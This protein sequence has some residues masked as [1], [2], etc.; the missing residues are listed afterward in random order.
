MTDLERKI[1]DHVVACGEDHCDCQ[2]EVIG[3][4]Q[5]DV[6]GAAETMVSRGVL[7]GAFPPNPNR[8][9]GIDWGYLAIPK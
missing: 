9:H 2:I 3:Y 6:L 5:D 8:R 4:D 7:V 1:Y